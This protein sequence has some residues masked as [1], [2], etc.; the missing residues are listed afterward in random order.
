LRNS[1]RKGSFSIIRSSGEGTNIREKGAR[2]E[3]ERVKKTEESSCS[4]EAGKR[5]QGPKPSP[6]KEREKNETM[7][8]GGAKKVSFV[9][10]TVGRE[11]GERCLRKSRGKK[12]DPVLKISSSGRK[13]GRK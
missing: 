10:R 1:D 9:H 4:K 13:R 6:G 11:M 7:A 12:E 3:E 5:G 8:Q 2:R